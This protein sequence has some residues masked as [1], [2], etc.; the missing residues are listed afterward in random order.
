M[1]AEPEHHRVPLTPSEPNTAPE[2]ARLIRLEVTRLRGYD[3]NPRRC[4]NS[5]YERIKA[6]IRS[7]G[8]DQPLVVTRRPGETDYMLL[9][10]GNSRLRA[11]RALYQETSDDAF[12]YLDCVYK[13]WV[14]ESDVLLSH[15]RENEL[16]DNLHFIDKARAVFEAKALLEAEMPG[17]P[18]SQRR[19]SELITAR[20]L[21]FSQ[22]LISRMAYAVHTLWPLIPQALSAGMGTPQVVR[23]Q[24]LER[25]ARNLWLSR[26]LGSDGEFDAIFAA[27]CRRYDSPDWVTEVLRGAIETEIADAADADIA[28][29]RLELEALIAGQPFPALAPECPAGESMQ[30]LPGEVAPAAGRGARNPPISRPAAKSTQAGATP[31]AQIQ[32]N[33]DTDAGTERE[34]NQLRQRAYRLARQLAEANGLGTLIQPLTDQGVGFAVQAVPDTAGTDLPDTDTDAVRWGA[35]LWWQLAACADVKS[36]PPG[37]VVPLEP[38]EAGPLAARLWRWLPDADWENLVALMEN[39]RALHRVARDAGQPLP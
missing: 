4:R 19:L 31:P 17:T 35:A 38:L 6:S 28:L 36:T 18:L 8:L 25:A 9:A 34:L 3:R 21:S 1:T 33:G 26:S 11:L 16:R 12:R 30:A 32:E 39:C 10:G 24:A 22:T 15:L 37:S 29:V 7:Q 27:L 13:P 23:I 5:E 2:G 14:A 20:G